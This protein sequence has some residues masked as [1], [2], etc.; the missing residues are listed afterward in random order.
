MSGNEA[1][2]RG[3]LLLLHRLG[4][5][6]RPCNMPGQWGR[7]AVAFRSTGQQVLDD[8]PFFK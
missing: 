2:G 5:V 8:R 6:N 3:K 7:S 1:N 4:P